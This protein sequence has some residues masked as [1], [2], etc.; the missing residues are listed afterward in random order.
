MGILAVLRRIYAVFRIGGGRLIDAVFFYV[1]NGLGGVPAAAQLTA[2]HA[3]Q[4]G[5]G[6]VDRP[7]TRDGSGRQAAVNLQIILIAIGPSCVGVQNVFEYAR[8]MR[9]GSLLPEA[10]RSQWFLPWPRY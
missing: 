5:H 10:G 4:V 2:V 1:R 9:S 7:H 8:C 6:V 3:I